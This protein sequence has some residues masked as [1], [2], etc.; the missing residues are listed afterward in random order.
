MA[1]AQVVLYTSD[2]TT[3][4]AKV[5]VTLNGLGYNSS[6]EVLLQSDVTK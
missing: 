1:W 3:P 2:V 6:G 5:Y 4:P